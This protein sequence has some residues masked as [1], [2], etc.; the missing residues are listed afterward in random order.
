MSL[1]L[2]D[3]EVQRQTSVEEHTIDYFVGVFGILVLFILVFHIFFLLS[4]Y[5]SLRR[6]TSNGNVSIE[7]KIKSLGVVEKLSHI[8]VYFLYKWKGNIYM[9]DNYFY[10]YQRWI[11]LIFFKWL[12]NWKFNVLIRLGEHYVFIKENI[13]LNVSLSNVLDKWLYLLIAVWNICLC[14]V[15]LFLIFI[16]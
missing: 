16:K 11:K 6:L 3:K 1:S 14:D 8:C 7:V 4:K 12:Y 10:F 13:L 9:K 5:L 2:E 15:K